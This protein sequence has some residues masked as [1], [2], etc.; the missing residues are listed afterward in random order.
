MNKQGERIDPRGSEPAPEARQTWPMA[1]SP[2]RLPGALP[3]HARGAWRQRAAGVIKHAAMG[4]VA[5]R[6]GAA[7]LGRVLPPVRVQLNQY[8]VIVPRLPP[9]LNGLRVLHVTD[10]HLSDGPHPADQIPAIVAATPHDLICYSGDFIDCDDDVPRLARFLERM[11]GG[12]PAYAVLG[13]HDYVPFGRGPGLNDAARLCEALDAAGIGIMSNQARPLYDGAL[14]L[15]GVDDPATG[16]DDLDRALDGLSG[17]CVLLLAH[18]PDIVLRLGEHCPSLILAG[19]TH[20]GQVRLPFIGPLLTESN[21]P[22]RLIMGLNEWHGTP[23]FVSRGVG[24]SGLNIRI[25][26][27]PE[28]AVLTL[29]SPAAA[30]AWAEPETGIGAVAIGEPDDAADSRCG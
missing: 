23:L 26:C 3:A 1:V 21:V 20:G 16:R 22:R 5:A 2:F 12:A 27:P 9:R 17:A 4:S 14:Y 24:F 18:S 28:V 10:L 8:E 11:P 30:A 15:A 25:G 19:H 13:N 6:A 29:R 7:L